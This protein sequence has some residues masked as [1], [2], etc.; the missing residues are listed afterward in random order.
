MSQTLKSINPW[1][2]QLVFEINESSEKEVEQSLM[3]LDKSFQQW[4]S[5]PVITRCAYIMAV[6]AKLKRGRD[7]YARM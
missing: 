4:K 5:T 1:N 7:D 3:A 6:A 2:K